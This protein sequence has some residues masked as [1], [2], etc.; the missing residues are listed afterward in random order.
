MKVAFVIATFPTTSETFIINQVGDLLDHGAEV[1]VFAF[2]RGGNEHISSRFYSYRMDQRTHYLWPPTL[3]GWGARDLLRNVCRLLF[4]PM[5]PLRAVQELFSTRSIRRML[6]ILP[7]AGR[8]FDVIHCHFG[9]TAN[10]FLPIRRALRLKTPLVTTF[11]GYDA[12]RVLNADPK[13]Y[14]ELTRECALFFVM[15]HDM[16]RRLAAQGFSEDKI[17]VLPVSIDVSAYHFCERTSG[18]GEAVELVCVARL[19]EKK[20]ID[21]LLSGLA[22]VRSR[23]TRPFRCSIIGS[24]PL[25]SELKALSQSLML[26]NVVDFK[27]AMRVDDVID[28]LGRMHIMVQPSKTARDGDME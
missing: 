24:G 28:F 13:A 6:L 18:P 17:A 4:N 20:G 3:R 25:E 8:T 23:S 27:G 15:S 9:V 1:E 26:G 10:D 2:Q 12:S 7:F 19:V 22:A 14:E 16:K 5:V 21:D 11:Y